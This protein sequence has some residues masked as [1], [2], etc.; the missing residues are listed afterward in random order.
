LTFLPGLILTVIGFLELVGQRGPRPLRAGL[1]LAAA[2]VF[3]IQAAYTVP[4]WVVFLL[5]SSGWKSGF[6]T[7]VLLALGAGFGALVFHGAMVLTHENYWHCVIEFHAQRQLSGFTLRAAV[8]SHLLQEPQ[9]ALGLIGASCLL[10]SGRPALRGLAGF[11][12]MSFVLTLFGSKFVTDAYFVPVWPFLL[13]CGAILLGQTPT[14]GTAVARNLLA[15]ALCIVAIQGI[16]LAP[17]FGYRLFRLAASEE[18]FIARVRATEGKT[19]LTTHVKVAYYAGK[20]PVS[21]YYNP[22]CCARDMTN[23]F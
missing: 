15:G 18:D 5:L 9:A 19:V 23:Q 8:L 22:D 17:I 14:P 21:D 12:L 10:L 6:R 7:S 3:R 16:V 11:C 2:S 1:W 4:G 20:K 13:V